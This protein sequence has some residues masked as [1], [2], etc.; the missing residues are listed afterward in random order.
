MRGHEKSNQLQRQS[1]KMQTDYDQNTSRISGIHWNF[2]IKTAM[3]LKE[4]SMDAK[5]AKISY[6][7]KST[8]NLISQGNWI[9]ENNQFQEKRKIVRKLFYG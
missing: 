8:T 1:K 4:I 9:V 3:W 7:R 6:I 5:R 2:R